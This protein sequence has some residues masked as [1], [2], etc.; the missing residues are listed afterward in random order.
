VD[1]V[2]WMVSWR[3]HVFS[4]DDLHSLKNAFIH[5]DGIFTEISISGCVDG[6]STYRCRGVAGGSYMDGAI[7]VL[8]ET[9]LYLHH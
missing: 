7:K 3:G 6:I 5:L 2:V 9:E 8:V 4:G 1:G